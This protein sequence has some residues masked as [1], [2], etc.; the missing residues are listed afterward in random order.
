MRALALVLAGGEGNRLDVLTEGRA[1]PAM[2]FAGVYKLI[3]FPLSNCMHS[4]ISDVWVVQ[5]YEPHS[6]NDHIANGRPWDLDKTHG[7]L[8]IL[9][10]HQGD[11]QEGGWHQGNA[12]SLFRNR[13]FIEEADPEVV[14]VLSSDHVY[15]LDYSAVITHHL[16]AGA[17]ATLVTTRVEKSEASRFGVVEVGDDDRVRDYEYK[18]DEP[19]SELV[20][21]EV[22]VFSTEPLMRNLEELTDDEGGDEG[23][24]DFGDELLPKMVAEGS[25]IEHRLE[26]YWRDLGTIASY[27]GAHMDL[28][29]NTPQLDLDDPEWPILTLAPQR[30]PAHIFESATNVNALV[31]PGSE[32]RGTVVN[33]VLAPGVV[34]EEGAYVRDSVILHDVRIGARAAIECAIIDEGVEIEESAVIGEQNRTRS[35]S[36]PSDDDIAVVGGRARIGR[37]RSISPGARVEP[38]AEL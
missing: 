33:S 22:F 21:T 15:K 38:G 37:G 28:L 26:G 24:S 4:G 6:L 5:Q 32:V 7:G 35:R 13:S 29:S 17:E 19:G 3:D 36:Q 10:P 30:P 16:D 20:T 25:V 14:V 18:P 2:P 9:A 11:D 34:V 1:K 12:D 31:S 23:L 27:W 8:R